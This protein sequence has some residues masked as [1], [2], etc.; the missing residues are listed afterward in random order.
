MKN[1]VRYYS[2]SRLWKKVPC[3]TMLDFLLPHHA[4]DTRNPLFLIMWQRLKLINSEKHL[5]Q[6]NQVALIGLPLLTITCWLGGGINLAQF[7]S[8]DAY[9]LINLTLIIAICMM[10]TSS[11]YS[12]PAI[13][14][15]LH[16]QLNSTYWDA[17]C[18][19][20]QYNSTILMSHD[21]IAQ[22]RLWPFTVTEVGLRISLVILL[23][24]N[25]FYNL[26]QSFPNQSDFLAQTLYSSTTWILCTGLLLL[27]LALMVEPIIRS[28]IIVTLHLIIAGYIRNTPLAVLA[29]FLGILV[30]HGLQTIFMAGLWFM[31]D[32]FARHKMGLDSVIYC[33]IPLILVA[34]VLFCM[35][36]AWLRKS[37]LTIAYH[38]IL[39][40]DR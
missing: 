8:I 12:I 19:T 7:A 34:A 20:P 25:N 11:L 27:A 6:S 36:L 26:Y 35:F 29:G 15:K 21:A 33:L 22:L 28:R 39:R 40:I 16:A 37:A 17:L 10:L 2:I 31:I 23:T 14:G 1:F 18:V 4:V 24:L 38:A 9:T 5:R 3:I 13:L 30:I 32:D